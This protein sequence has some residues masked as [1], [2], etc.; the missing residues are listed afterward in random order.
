[1]I[2]RLKK[3]RT[4]LNL[5]QSEFAEQL[6]LQRNTISLL[7]TGKRNPSERTIDDICNIFNVSKEYLLNG[8]EPMFTQTYSDTMEQLKKEFNLDEFSF[9]LVHEYLKLDPAQREKVRDFFYRV[10][11]LESDEQE[12]R[13]IQQEAD[14]FGALARE[15]FIAEKRQ[16]S[17]TLSVKKSDAS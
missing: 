2:E 15:Q 4:A 12:E 5:T 9:N 3:I 17:Q 10:V 14:E 11:E 1:V 16:E 13:S 6:R 7:E 8:T